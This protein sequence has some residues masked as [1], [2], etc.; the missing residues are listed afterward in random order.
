MLQRTAHLGSDMTVVKVAHHGSA[1]QDAGLYEAL[2]PAVAVISVGE[3][4][5]YGHPRAEILA[6]L[7]AVGAHVLRT[8]QRGR[9]LIGMKDGA[10]EVWT[11]RSV[12]GPG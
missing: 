6:I 10:V 5:D 12:G 11:E 4:N 9:I 8:D 2:R 1:D 3:G 7:Q